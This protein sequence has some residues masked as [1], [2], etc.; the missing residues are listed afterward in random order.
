[1]RDIKTSNTGRILRHTSQVRPS[2]RKKY[3]TTGSYISY[4]VKLEWRLGCFKLNR[5]QKTR[6][7]E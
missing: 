7:R 5:F 3:H 6:E 2:V 4:V 1:M